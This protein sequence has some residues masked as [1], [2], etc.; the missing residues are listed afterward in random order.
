MTTILYNF[1]PRTRNCELLL[2]QNLH[3]TPSDEE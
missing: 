2:G 1:L 3:L